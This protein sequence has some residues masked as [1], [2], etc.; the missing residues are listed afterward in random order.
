LAAAKRDILASEFIKQKVEKGTTDQ[1]LRSYFSKSAKEYSDKEVRASHILFKEKDLNLANQVLKKAIAGA[2][3]ANLAK[4]HSAGPSGP[5]GGDL[6]F[7]KKGKMVPAFDAAAFSTPKGKVHGK[8]VKTR[9]G[10]HII[11]VVDV[12]GSEK[13]NFKKKRRLIK[14]KVTNEIKSN[15]IKNLRKKYEVSVDENALKALNL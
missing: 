2:N 1:A 14:R 9:F 8:L 13:P 6:G 10:L 12:K 3:F 4:A 11:K 15:V 7:F 5:K